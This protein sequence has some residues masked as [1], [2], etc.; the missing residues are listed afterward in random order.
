M[1]AMDF[2]YDGALL[3]SHGYIA[4]LF[5]SSGGFN[6]VSAGSEITFNTVS[7]FGGKHHILT[8]T[9]YENCLT[10]TFDI[11][12]DPDVYYGRDRYISS[13]EFRMLMRWLNRKKF[14]PFRVVDTDHL[15]EPCYYDVSFNIERL[16]IGEETIGL[17]LTANT[18]R[19]FGYGEEKVFEWTAGSG[20]STYVIEDTSDEIGYIYPKVKIV[21]NE[22]GNMKWQNTQTLSETTVINN[23]TSGET[24]TIDGNI[25]YIS[26]ADSNRKI[27]DDFN[28]VFP[29]IGNSYDNQTNEININ[30]ACNVTLSYIPIIKESF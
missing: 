7:S 13:A 18:N 17:R 4:C 16:T 19:P 6:S 12:K 29:K 30:L 25:L 3:S 11:C 1:Y 8:G 10:A 27:V 28:F 24:I 21:V 23:C 22:S 15:A 26:S 2:E 5:E 14:L 20:G 9:T